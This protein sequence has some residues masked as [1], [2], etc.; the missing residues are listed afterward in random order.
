MVYKSH[1]NFDVNTEYFSKYFDK[2]F[3]TI[4]VAET[5]YFEYCGDEHSHI[6]RG[7]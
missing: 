7:L 6:L 5:K 2:Q 4:I 3:M 1:V